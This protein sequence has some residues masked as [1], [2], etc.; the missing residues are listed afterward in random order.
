MT[1]LTMPQ[2]RATLAKIAKI[3]AR[4]AKRGLAGR[5]DV[6]A[7]E[8]HLVQITERDGI[9]LPF[10][11]Y[12]ERIEVDLT[13]EA[14]RYVDWVFAARI[15]VQGYDEDGDP[16]FTLATAPGVEH[17]DREGIDAG[18]CE[19]CGTRRRRK[20]TYVLLNTGE[21]DPATAGKR[22]VVGSTCL[23]DF[24]GWEGRIAWLDVPDL[25]DEDWFGSVASVEPSYAVADVLRLAIA[26]IRMRGYIPGH[27]Y[28]QTSTREHVGTLFLSRPTSADR[29]TA[30]ALLVAA[31]SVDPT[32]VAAIIETLTGEDYPGTGASASTYAEN[33]KV[34]LSLTH[35]HA[36][37]LGLLVSAPQAYAKHQGRAIER[38]ARATSE[39]IGTKGEKITATIT[40]ERLT[41]IEQH[42]GGRTA[43]STLLTGRTQTGEIV[44][45]FTAAAWVRDMQV[46]QQVT[47]TATVKDHEIYEG[48]KQTLLTRA[49]PVA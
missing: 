7:G 30:E 24:L 34:L 38:A 27:A 15:D 21:T 39:W 5:I 28:G 44:K 19:H 12:E 23:R 29:E 43:Y 18:I 48:T 16:V 13:G 17:L 3:N 6:E 20:N 46:G 1:S 37:G 25:S 40:I 45:C 2:Y 32:E 22:I 41:P 4:A 9:T 36:S 42:F 10:P 31:E 11:V 14:P 47:L 8:P 33:L 26:S 35:V 49:K